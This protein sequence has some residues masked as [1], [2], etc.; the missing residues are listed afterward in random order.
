MIARKRLDFWLLESKRIKAYDIYC[1]NN[2][3]IYIVI[4]LEVSSGG[5]SLAKIMI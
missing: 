1:S 2:I 4:S 3:Y 5:L